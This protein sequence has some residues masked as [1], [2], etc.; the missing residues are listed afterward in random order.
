M[1]SDAVVFGVG[2]VFVFTFLV[3]ST[4]R[5]YSAWVAARLLSEIKSIN[6]LE[7]VLPVPPVEKTERRVKEAPRE[8][9]YVSDHVPKKVIVQD[10]ELIHKR[11]E[12]ERLMD[13]YKAMRGL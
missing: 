3:L 9:T 12:I 1:A 11:K 13:E 6:S 8:A 7:S 4:I 5:T 10:D 2:G